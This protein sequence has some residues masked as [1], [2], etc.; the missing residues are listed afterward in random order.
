MAPTSQTVLSNEIRVELYRQMLRAQ[1]W[2]QRLLRFAEE[3][4]TSGFYHAGRGQEAAAVGGVLPLR[5]DDYLLYDHRGLGHVIAKDVPI[6]KLF[7]DFLGYTNGTTRGLGA[8]IVHIAWPERGVLGQSGTL[9]GSFVIAA[10]AGLSARYRRTDQVVLCFFGEGTANRGTFHEAMNVAALWDLPIVWLCVNNGWSVSVSFE[11]ATSVPN[12]ADRASAYGIPGQ[13]VD[14]MDPEAVYTAVAAATERARDGQ[15]PTLIEAKA[16]RYRGHYEGD[17]ADYRSEEEKASWMERDPLVTYRQ[18][19]LD[20]GISTT[21]LDA[22]QEQVQ[23][24]IDEAADAA[25][26]GKPPE[27]SRIFEGLYSDNGAV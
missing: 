21:D 9:G 22:L 23:V 3:G 1:L 10:G 20:L 27:R 5:R 16:Y 19:L 13:V 11:A 6:D 7:A 12:I 25:L 2:E 24:E 26:Q 14:G 17:P 8:G 18:R 4:R 15:G